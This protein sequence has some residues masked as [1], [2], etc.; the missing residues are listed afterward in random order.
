MFAFFS[1]FFRSSFMPQNTQLFGR[2]L[3]PEPAYQMTILP[4]YPMTILPAYPKIILPAYPKIILPAYP[5]ASLLE[6]QP[7]ADGVYMPASLRR[8]YSS[9]LRFFSPLSCI[10]FMNSVVTPWS[11]SSTAFLRL[12]SAKPSSLN[13]FTKAGFTP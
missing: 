1:H 11:A 2:R 5:T 10:F 12:I 6:G 7:P 4:A 9:R 8:M 3:T 13:R